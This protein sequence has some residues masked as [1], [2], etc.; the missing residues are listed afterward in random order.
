MKLLTLN[1]HSLQ[2]ENYEQKLNWFVEGI[3]Q[4]KPDMIALQEV[5]QTAA[6]ELA[7]KPL[8][9]GQYLI[10]TQVPLRKDN[11]AAR[12]AYRLRQAGIPCCW[13]WLP[14]KRGY[15]KYDEGVAILSLGRK[16]T[17]ADI[18]P[19]SRANDYHNWRTRAV[20]GV[21]VEGMTDWFYTI[22]M[23]W[24]DDVEEPFREQWAILEQSLSEKR[25]KDTVWLMGDFNGPDSISGESYEHILAHG[26]VDT[27]QKA[28]KKDCGL[29]VSHV[30]DG[31]QER[32]QDKAAM[33]LDYIFCSCCTEVVSSR[34]VFNGENE[35]AVSDHFGVLIDIKEK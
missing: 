10:P 25:K 28:K 3:L 24:W 32:L 19:I 2:E 21:Q 5:N 22:H 33:R 4:E 18:F 35:P 26:W 20:L 8:W 34:V 12:V 23:G 27:Y 29:T 9:E 11:H 7:E 6:E 13:V 16:I 14:V 30:I 31:W 17:A 15:G 1:T